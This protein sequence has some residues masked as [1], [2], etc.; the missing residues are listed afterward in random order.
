MAT[1]RGK[2]TTAYTAALLGSVAVF[3]IALFAARRSSARREAQ[4]E[5]ALQADL[6][7]RVLRNAAVDT[8]PDPVTGSVITAPGL[9]LRG[10]VGHR[11]RRSRRGAA[12]RWPR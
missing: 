7:L 11:H 4:R 1:I 9:L 3:S 8:I 10:H 6:A 2:L 12:A 5:V